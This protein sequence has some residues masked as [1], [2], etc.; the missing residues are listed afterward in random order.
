MLLVILRT[1][2][3]SR[4]RKTVEKDEYKVNEN[5]VWNITVFNAGNGTN[6]T[7]VTLKDILPVEVEFVSYTATNGTYDNGTGIWDIGFMGNGTNATLT[8][9]SKAVTTKY[10]ITNNATVKKNGIIPITLTMRPLALF[11]PTIRL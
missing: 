7:N 9:V 6:A 5:V 4:L 3:L 8:I 1:T 10:N 11:Q 2:S